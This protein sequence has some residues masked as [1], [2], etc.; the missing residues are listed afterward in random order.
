VTT[1][2]IH[3]PELEELARVLRCRQDGVDVLQRVGDGLL[4]EHV[5]ARLEGRYRHLAM[6]VVGDGDYHRLASRVIKEFAVVVEEPRLRPALLGGQL[7]EAQ[8]LPVRVAEADDDGVRTGQEGAQVG[9]ALRPQA[10]DADADAL[11]R[12]E[13]PPRT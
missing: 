6:P 3:Q 5:L 7:R 8:G 11:V 1:V 2:S 12:Q 9:V 10:D 13:T 4:Q